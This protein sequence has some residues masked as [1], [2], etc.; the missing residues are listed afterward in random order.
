MRTFAMVTAH[1]A[2]SAAFCCASFQFTGMVELYLYIRG[3]FP[4]AAAHRDDGQR[5]VVRADEKLTAFLELES[6]IL[7]A[8]KYE[9]PNELYRSGPGSISS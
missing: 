1:R 5:F 4:D 7:A 9:I 6:A 3:G 8:W 2:V